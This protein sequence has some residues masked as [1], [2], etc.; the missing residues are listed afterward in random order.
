MKL[1]I[2]LVLW[3]AIAFLAWKLYSSIMA[4]VKFNEVKEARYGKVIEKL[5][6]IQSAQLAYKEIKGDFTGSYDSLINFVETAQ[7]AITSR[8]DTSYPDRVKNKAYGLDPETGG[9]IIEAIVSDT[10]GFT[11]VKDS[12]YA[13]TDRYKNMMN[14]NIN[15]TDHKIDL[16]AGT[17]NK[18]DV[19]YKVFEAKIAKDKILSDLDKDLLNQEKQVLS[20]DGVNGEYIQVGSMNDVNTAGNW[21]K[22][23]DFKKE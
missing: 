11:P 21:P 5:K 2:Q 3:V 6:D 15:G 23:Y 4:P 10:L 7:F 14:V 12:L 20:V 13:G 9:Y 18:G 19:T 22:V 17:L 8:K 1:I 16:E